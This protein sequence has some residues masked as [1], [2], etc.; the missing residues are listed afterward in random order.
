MHGTKSDSRGVAR[1]CRKR[2][3][4]SPR[5]ATAWAVGIA[6]GLFTTPLAAGDPLYLYHV[7]RESLTTTV[8]GGTSWQNVLSYTTP[9]LEAEDDWLIIAT[10]EGCAPRAR[11][12]VEYERQVLLNDTTQIGYHAQADEGNFSTPS[13]TYFQG[14]SAWVTLGPGAHT[15]KIQYKA[16]VSTAWTI[17]NVRVLMIRKGALEVHSNK[18]TY[19]DTPQ[20]VGT[21]FATYASVAF[22]P[23]TA[24][25]YLL[26]YSAEP[27]SAAAYTASQYVTT[28]T[29]FHNGTSESTIDSRIN[30]SWRDNAGHGNTF[31]FSIVD[32]PATTCTLSL[33]A[34]AGATTATMRRARVTA[35][36]LDGS[37]FDGY[38]WAYG[39]D[40]D[41]GE[42]TTGTA[43]LNA[44]TLPVTASAM[45]DMNYA[46][47]VSAGQ[48]ATGTA[49]ANGMD[50]RARVNGAP[51]AASWFMAGK[52]DAVYQVPNVW[53]PAGGVVVKP[54]SVGA[55]TGLTLDYAATASGYTAWLR[56]VHAIAL[57]LGGEDPPPPAYT[58]TLD[59]IP[60]GLE[61]IAEGDPQ[62]APY[63]YTLFEGTRTIGVNSPQAAGVGSRY[64]WQ[65]WSDSGAQT[66]DID[67]QDD[68]SLTA[69]FGLE[70]LWTVT[71]DPV[72]GGSVSHPTAWHGDGA[73]FTATAT[74]EDGWEFA[75]W[76][77]DYTDGDPDL[78]VTMD[79]PKTVTANFEPVAGAYLVTI[80]TDPPGLVVEVDGDPTTGQ[81]FSWD[82]DSEHSL[83]VVDAIQPGAPGVRYVWERWS[84]DG[85][86]SHQV[87]ATEATT[88][89]AEFKTQYFWT[90]NA[91]P[92]EGGE[93]APPSGVWY[94]A[95]SAFTATAS[96]NAGYGFDGWTGTLSGGDDELA[97]TMTGPVTVTGHF[98]DSAVTRR[99][100][101][102][103]ATGLANGTS[104]ANAF[105]DLQAA[106]NAATAGE[107]VWVAA[108]TYKPG[109]ATTSTYAPKTG[110]P[111]Y[112]G[113][114]G[115]ESVRDLRDW[116]INVSILSGEIGDPGLQSD[117]I[118]RI[119]T[120]VNGTT[121]D[122]FRLTRA[123][124][125]ANY[126]GAISIVNVGPVVIR[127]C[128][129]ID[130]RLGTA[131][132]SRAAAIFYQY[133]SGSQTLLVDR[134]A[135]LG[136]TSTDSA[137]GTVT[138][139]GAA[140]HLAT[141]RN[142]VFSGNV[143]GGVNSGVLSTWAGHA[144]GPLVVN[145]TFVNNSGG[146]DM[147][148][149][150]ANSENVGSLRM[151]NCIFRGI[152]ISHRIR[153][154]ST[155]LR[156][157]NCCFQ[158]YPSFYS[159]NNSPPAPIDEGGGTTSFAADPVF[160]SALGADATA[161]TLDDNVRLQGTSPCINAGTATD[162][163]AHD[164]DGLARPQ[165]VGGDFDIGA[166]EFEIPVYQVTL[167]TVPTG[168]EVTAESDTQT[169][170]HAYTLPQGTRTISVASPQSGGTGIRYVW[171]SWSDSGAQSHAISVTEDAAY[172]ATFGSEYLWTVT[173]NPVAGGTV[174]A[175]TAWHPSGAE[176]TAT[177][178]PEDGW[179]FAGWTGD[180]TSGDAALDVTMDG[181]K[182]VTANFEPEVGSFQITI[183]T[184]PPGLEIVVDG[185]PT[186]GNTFAWDENS[187][188]TLNVAAAIQPGAAGVRYVFQR[189]SNDGDQSQVLTV[190]GDA[191]ITAEFD[192][193]YLWSVSA[194]PV[195]GG[196]VGP[197]SAVWYDA[198]SV[199]TATAEMNTGWRF[200]GWTGTLS[201]NDPDLT[202]TMNA[203]VTVTAH[204]VARR[205]VNHAAAGTG[206]GNSWANAFTS[207]QGALAAVSGG[208]LWVAQGTYKP[209]TLTS[210]TFQMKSGVTLI[211]GFAGT[212]SLLSQRA[213]SLCPT[214][215]S[216]DLN[217]DD[218]GNW[219]NRSDNSTRIVTGI[220]G[221]TLDGF[222]ISGGNGVGS[223]LYLAGG[224]SPT[225]RRCV[226]ANNRST[227]NGG[228]I[229]MD[230]GGAPVFEDCIFSDHAAAA[231]A[232]I[233]SGG[234]SPTIRRCVFTG[235]I[236]TDNAGALYFANAA[237]SPHIENCLFAGNQ[238]VYTGVI[239]LDGPSSGGPQPTATVI[240]STFTDNR[241][242]QWTGSIYVRRLST[243]TLRNSIS[244]GNS[245][246]GGNPEIAA[247]NSG[248]IQ[249]YYCN[250][251]HN[252]GGSLVD[253]NIAPPG[254]NPLFAGGPSGNWTTVG[255]FNAA[256]RQTTLTLSGAGW[257]PG[258]LVGLLLNPN[259]AQ[260]L[261]FVIAANGADTI[262]VWG[263]AAAV[264][265]A[266]N[267]FQVND[268]RIGSGSPCKD[269]GN[270]VG[271]ADHDLQG[272]AR[273]QN[274]TV[275]MGA[276]EYIAP[277]SVTV[278]SSPTGRELLVNGSLVTAPQTYTWVPGATHAIGAAT[279]Q[280]GAVGTRYAWQSWSDGG[281]RAHLV[282][283]SGAETL[284]AAFSTQYLWTASASP[285]EAGA[286]L[287]PGGQ[288]Y[289]RD[290]TFNAEATAEDG[291][292][293]AEWTGDLT[294]NDP[295]LPV[296]MSGPVTVTAHF[297]VEIGS[298]LVTVNTDPPGLVVLVDGTPTSA[299]TYSWD[300]G[301][302]HT[303]NVADPIQ[304][305]T[306]GVR[307]VWQHW[308]NA[309]AQSHTVTTD[310]DVTIT[311]VFET[312]Y[313]WEPTVVNP[314]GGSVTPAAGWYPAGSMFDAV[315]Q[316]NAGYR[317]TGWAGDLTG[318]APLQSV[319]M[320]G[321]V[322][323]TA[324]FAAFRFVKHNATGANDGSSWANAYTS[325]QTAL[326]AV[327]AGELWVA[328]GTYRPGALTTDTFA[329][330][331][332]VTLYG[333][334][335]GVE[336]LLSQRVWSLHPTILSGDL[337]S[338][339]TG[340]WGNR[341]D[342]AAR[343]VTGITGGTLDGFIVS[344]GNG[345]GSGLY[346]AG[347][348]SPTVRHCV[349]VNNRSTG[350]GGAVYMDGG[351]TPVFEDCVFSDQA[352]GAGAAL[353]SFG[354]SP[355]FRRCVFAGGIVTDNAGALYFANAAGSPHIENCLF[356]GNQANFTGAIRLDGP[357][358]GGPQPTAT[359]I[360]STFT[361]NRV[362]QFNG[363][364]Y[365]RRLSTLTL[366]NSISWGNSAGGGNFEIAV[367]NG[368]IIQAYYCNIAHNAGGSLVE[369]NIAPPG[370]NPLFAG[371]PSGNWTVV[372]AFNA[373]TR[374]TTLMLNGA[375]WTPGA[376]AGLLLNPNTAQY[377]QF[378]IA[379]NGADTITVW[380]DAAAVTGVGNAFQVNDY[381]LTATSP[382]KDTASTTAAPNH[383]LQGVDRP[384]GIGIDMGAYEFAAPV[385]MTIDTDPSGLQVQV[386][387]SL[388]T[389][390]LSFAWTPGTTHLVAA[391]T[392][393]GWGD[394][395]ANFEAWSDGGARIHAI[396]AEETT[397]TAT[398]E[399]RDGLTILQFR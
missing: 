245:A 116:T 73:T 129:F 156:Y 335:A 93:V 87:T 339:D 53:L 217:G 357:T 30:S 361:A 318:D 253:G 20:S 349:F 103:A 308:S 99:F 282:T 375:G 338:D 367:E 366:R 38:Q 231:G 58:V 348:V 364:I 143:G 286:V 48:R 18:A 295:T 309:G 120:A 49:G 396:T 272:V 212:E 122:G 40:N 148:L 138:L 57:P 28:E 221:G 131:G 35:I 376:L 72:E 155:Q 326:A 150:S 96:P 121:L 79:G 307:Y 255:A 207:L 284:L 17:R 1:A 15:I 293:F 313:W 22:T 11:S 304:A 90:V 195:A 83:S 329:M 252:A 47:L 203:P 67:V 128:T 324:T 158:S 51:A 216:G 266:G 362:A 225:V 332:G 183:N 341:G 135:F 209:G 4:F 262:T 154:G 290:T 270:N 265:G 21:S 133:D 384:Q 100:V 363:S 194:D 378:A 254:A 353:Y 342:N 23:A 130:N 213:W 263:D 119:V 13:S 77:G 123:N 233:Y 118:R 29:R 81:I 60:T 343:I 92:E 86:Q 222:I 278:D 153:Y 289:D 244:W 134:C 193:Q 246:G 296:T 243:L 26:I 84:N 398:Y 124:A 32:A 241:V 161:G 369:G 248:V 189:W 115:T 9:V 238:A 132:G 144:V 159:G 117:N 208:E 168:L 91:S 66:H 89:T 114:A 190:T 305:G 276:Y 88:I 297:D 377:L 267:A 321:P 328:Q 397:L 126:D 202:V 291:W 292:L 97:V 383:D 33:R 41:T 2:S 258:A 325:L 210:D 200:D 107:E 302:E 37:R 237:G 110:V 206:D 259:T 31:G 140:N 106:I 160:V 229:Y 314:A 395:I 239:R 65:N 102:V 399:L 14:S 205:F 300:G 250:I 232:A 174:S 385:T 44:V 71:V 55:N 381:R 196:T 281:A 235:G 167:S 320:N 389:A 219:G 54:M 34:L 181:P 75:G 24:G 142:S 69:T 340:S 5:T 179:V 63:A 352:A 387:G 392:P 42:S 62:T 218:T 70:H 373:A 220:T 379:A 394:Q 127:N 242:S 249:A 294:G 330:K 299:Q 315:A 275:D 347:G 388:G 94:D 188:H 312:Q 360:N 393:Q 157:E 344:G 165:P 355:T 350:N 223:G 80:A 104:W 192:T 178:I 310:A 256:T 19:S 172:T 199:F 109:A 271:A 113:F 285:V 186:T 56:R 346:L 95:D 391:P 374:Q 251:A 184:D 173:T 198:G 136:N 390:P 39:N 279:P 356:A 280:A 45:A 226:F 162:A 82:A 176:F 151:R 354:G 112:G 50:L 298:Y 6:L 240:N 215:L 59:T 187:E 12:Y 322:A 108:G 8:T 351:A 319:T 7:E 368:G 337:N 264:A 288:W 323:A 234:G 166:F 283:V 372:G 247:E 317:L 76:A 74:A 152:S 163:P 101:D 145:C 370:A 78:D 327:S 171:Q 185:N 287:P 331:S 169:A 182:T 147:T 306:P 269:T 3:P 311:A 277:V 111:L 214:I 36:R 257:T 98:A 197:A 105:T 382:S 301:S 175:P 27:K 236:V 146:Y 224:A 61:V 274:G 211:G 371:G 268:Y 316:P 16:G 170:P 149:G 139:I 64:V 333:G 358:S 125:A 177:A 43:W 137:L 68:M 359:V 334:F 228:A 25:K 164:F 260:Y 303:L 227:G 10:S 201:G 85:A 261:Q 336:S 52:V 191:T 380:G 273:P 345:I 46:F 204:F 141:I 180:Y 365:V 386:N 230:G